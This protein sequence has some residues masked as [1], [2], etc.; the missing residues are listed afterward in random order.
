MEIISCQPDIPEL[1][2]ENS[3]NHNLEAA[4]LQSCSDQQTETI[5]IQI[6]SF[7]EIELPVSSQSVFMFLY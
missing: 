2:E 6:L 5:E 1:Q 4:E 3:S 7:P